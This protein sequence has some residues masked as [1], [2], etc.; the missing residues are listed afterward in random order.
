MNKPMKTLAAA[1]AAVLA[2]AASAFD[3]GC[4]TLDECK[5]Y[6]ERALAVAE[7]N[8]IDGCG[9]LR[10]A[11]NNLGAHNKAGADAAAVK[12]YCAEIDGRIADVSARDR[13][14]SVGDWRCV[15]VGNLLFP[16]TH[17]AA[18]DK[19]FYAAGDRESIIP[20]LLAQARGKGLFVNAYTVADRASADEL[21]DLLNEAFVLVD[22]KVN[23]EYQYYVVRKL[24]MELQKKTQRKVR[25]YLRGQGKSFVTK[26]GV[27]PCA[28]V[29][30]ELVAALNAPR[31]NGVNEWLEK[32]GATDG[33]IDVSKLP[34]E[35]EVAQ[36]KDDVLNGVKDMN[37][38]SEFVLK[39]CLGVEGYNS[40][41]REFNGEEGEE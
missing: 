4:E 1:T 32:V 14:A 35:E 38:T 25:A 26:D 29:M 34:T 9:M 30:A 8:V 12:A 27:N 19:G 7:T 11:V 18:F 20:A 6:A 36:L 10:K 5:A 16:K 24:S 40:F 22:G 3:K 41:V 15:Y 39:V 21:V 17:Q 37:A 23:P 2:G 33:R 13:R 31:L 28:T